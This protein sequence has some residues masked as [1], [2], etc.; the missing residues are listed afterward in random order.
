[1]FS[2]KNLEERRFWKSF[3]A[4]YKQYPEIWDPRCDKYSR[5]EYKEVAYQA[6]ANKLKEIDPYASTDCVKRRL[7]IFKSNYKRELRRRTKTGT[8]GNLWYFDDLDFLIDID[9]NRIK[10]SENKSDSS[11]FY[12]P[13]VNHQVPGG[14]KNEVLDNCNISNYNQN[15]FNQ[16]GSSFGSSDETTNLNETPQ[17]ENPQSSSFN[18]CASVFQGVQSRPDIS[19]QSQPEDSLNGDSNVDEDYQQQ[20]VE[21]IAARISGNLSQQSQQPE[22][23]ADVYSRGWATTFRKIP[24]SQQQ[25][26]KKLIDDILYEGYMG[27]LAEGKVQI[28]N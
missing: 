15:L 7:N 23:D 6:L 9:K 13:E 18:S 25:L 5:R 14:V 1:M 2:K 8:K 21:K 20:S 24:T 16:V 11:E 10:K 28:V 26:A 22:D 19:E 3:L 12:F 17:M 27:R 4:L